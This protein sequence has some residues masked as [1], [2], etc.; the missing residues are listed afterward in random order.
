MGYHIYHRR[1]D[2]QY[3]PCGGPAVIFKP[4]ACYSDALKRLSYLV[5][6]EMR[7]RHSLTT[8]TPHGIGRRSTHW[9]YHMIRNSINVIYEVLESVVSIL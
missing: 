6:G 5:T 2:L 7:Q 4:F 3:C 1:R 8:H 9:P